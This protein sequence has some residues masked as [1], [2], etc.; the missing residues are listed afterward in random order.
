[1][2][3]NLK[4]NQDQIKYNKNERYIKPETDLNHKLTGSAKAF[5]D[6]FCSRC[7]SSLS[8]AY[9][10]NEVSNITKEMDI[11]KQLDKPF[12]N[13]HV[14]KTYCKFRLRIVDSSP[15]P[16]S[17]SLYN[18]SHQHPEYNVKFDIEEIVLSQKNF[19]I[20]E[21]TEKCNIKH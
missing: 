12:E 20:Q 13:R 16:R 6:A 21:I 2:K 17:R 10:E 15:P 8:S 11:L 9:G 4:F 19:H 1:M 7:H 5:G 14:L 3:R 18:E